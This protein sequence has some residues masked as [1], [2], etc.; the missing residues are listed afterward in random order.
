MGRNFFFL[1]THRIQ[2]TVRRSK[3][4]STTKLI[5]HRN[6]VEK[7][8]SNKCSNFERRE[9]SPN[10]VE[11]LVSNL[12]HLFENSES[13]LTIITGSKEIICQRIKIP[14]SK[15]NKILPPD[16]PYL[17]ITCSITFQDCFPGIFRI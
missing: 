4:T 10:P 8:P 2:K 17:N 7:K 3:N 9:S 16:R 5:F 12:S 13:F 1:E 14:I 6:S 11:G 15:V